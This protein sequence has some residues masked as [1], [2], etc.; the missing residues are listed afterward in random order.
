MRKIIK[1]TLFVILFSVLI[2]FAV[3]FAYL[4]FYASND[5]TLSGNWTASLDMTEQAAVTALGWLQDIEAVS[6]SMQDMESHMQGLTVDLRLT[7][8]QSS[9]SEGTFVSSVVPESY[10]A[11]SQAAYEAFAAVFRELVAE[12]LR[13]AGYTGGTDE[14]DIEA[15]VAETFGM[16]TTAYLMSS[17]PSLLPPLEELQAQYDCSGT[18]E[19]AEG[20]LTR[21]FDSGQ[22]VRT[23]AERYIRQDSTLILSGAVDSAYYGYFADHYPVIYTLQQPQTEQ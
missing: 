22:L 13:M 2:L 12:R 16:S 20:I 11:C 19:T 14:D 7:M 9:R 17:V 23:K 1:N 3:Y 21:Q 15:L 4:H 8:T 5:K 10:A 18:Y 6:V